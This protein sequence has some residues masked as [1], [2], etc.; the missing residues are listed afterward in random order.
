MI[1]YST[2]AS[3]S[4][5]IGGTAMAQD[6]AD[7]EARQET[8]V[9]TGQKIERS[10]QDTAVSVAVVTD[11][12]LEEDNIIDFVDAIERTANVT[13]RDGGNFTIRGINSTNVSGGGQGDLATIY[14]DGT[15][16]P[17]QASFAAPV[18]IWD[19]SQIELFR[20]PQSTL[21][22]R[23]SLAGAIIINT[24][25]PS[26][27]WEGRARAIYTTESEE[28]RLGVA[29]GGPIIDDQVA[30]R[31]SYEGSESDEFGFNET[32]NEPSNSIETS[33]LRGKLLIEPS[34][35]P[36]LEVILS[37]SHDERSSGEAFNVLS[38]DDPEENRTNFHN[39]PIRYETDIDIATATINYDL[40][41]AW[42]L[43]SITGWNEVDYRF[44]FDDDRSAADSEFRTFE[45]LIETWTQE[46]RGQY[47]GEKID[48]VVGAYYSTVDTPRS[49]SRG[50]LGLDPTIDLGLPIVLAQ[51]GVPDALIPT[52]VGLY[53]NPL[54]IENNNDFT[55][56]VETYAVF[57]DITWEFSDKWTLFAGARYD[58]EKQSATNETTIPIVTPLPDPA[59]LP[60]DLGGIVAVVNGLF[61]AD[62]QA[63]TSPFIEFESDEFGGFLPKVGIG[64][65]FDELRSLSFSIQRG[66]R[67]GGLG[68]NTALGEP[69]EFDQEF[70]WN[71]ELAF[72]SQWLDQALTLNANAF[73][74]DWTDQ[75]V[76][77]QLS[78]NIF[79]SEVTNAGSSSVV[80]FEIETAYE[81][82]DTVDLYGSVG[83]AKTE[84]EDFT[85]GVN[86]ANAANFSECT[87]SGTA[88][89]LCDFSG[90]EFGFA[91]QW[92]LNAGATWQPSENWIA[93]INANH[94]SAAFIRGDRP[95]ASRDSDERT[96]VNF[97]AGWQNENFGI[98]LSGEN[99]LD[100]DYLITQFPNDPLLDS[101]PEFAQFGDPRTFSIQLEARF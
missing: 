71:Y 80:G 28:T 10:L 35:I 64:Y 42:S 3:I 82:S 70:I 36:E 39:D 47:D 81:A 4:L 91:P 26:Y 14:V 61:I 59:L 51:F 6:T 73:Y 88:N 86:S 50:A 46:V 58:V 55:S 89:F 99:L 54:V 69:F 48:A 27:E 29:F 41:D 96:L 17:R 67:S 1:K 78:N 12:Q 45:T 23:A 68:V 101:E 22:G 31:L 66:Y 92:T 5:L 62:A 84:F 95:Q 34:A 7:K 15:A 9:V 40:T 43:T 100:E 18:D 52:V 75:Q 56:E 11:I 25:D 98:Y 16:L 97:R 90:N 72:R 63:A 83:Y 79:D 44:Q 30:F 38:V 24:A 53:P 37:Y 93:N 13:T 8:I 94:V 49:E 60:P 77:V 65:D 21:Q 19:V 20:G 85:I 74:I 32:R 76:R 87:A 57:T 33:V 2:A